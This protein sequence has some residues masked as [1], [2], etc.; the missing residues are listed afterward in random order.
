MRTVEAVGVLE[1]DV[2]VEDDAAGA[3]FAGT[4]NDPPG[5]GATRTRAAGSLRDVEAVKLEEAGALVGDA[6]AAEDAVRRILG[7]GEPPGAS[8]RSARAAPS[9]RRR[10]R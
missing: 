4:I 5:E 1:M 8:R 6:D 3:V 9:G 2:A 10:S 7:D